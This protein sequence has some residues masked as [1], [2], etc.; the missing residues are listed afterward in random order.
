MI[1]KI[2]YYILFGKSRQNVILSY[3]LS[4]LLTLVFDS[5]FR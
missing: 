4:L 5:I 3:V 2:K 1:T